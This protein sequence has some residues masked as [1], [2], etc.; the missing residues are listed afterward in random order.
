MAWRI[1]AID[2]QLEGD[3]G[4]FRL[5]ALLQGAEIAR[6]VERRGALGRDQDRRGAV[7]ARGRNA[8]SVDRQSR[9]RITG[10]ASSLCFAC[11]PLPLGGE[12]GRGYA[13][14]FPLT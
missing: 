6:A 9:T 14:Q 13:R 8:A 4:E 2:D 10:S 5:G 7:G 3:V 1:A 12:V 11:A